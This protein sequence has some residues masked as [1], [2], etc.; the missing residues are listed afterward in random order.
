MSHK[1]IPLQVARITADTIV[2][3]AIFMIALL[4]NSE[5]AVQ[6]VHFCG[7]ML[8]LHPTGLSIHYA[9]INICRIKYKILIAYKRF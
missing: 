2:M 5:C 8:S 4:K 1:A 3:L 6:A 7:I 9:Y